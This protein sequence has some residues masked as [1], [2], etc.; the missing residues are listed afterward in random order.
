MKETCG[1]NTYFICLSLIY[2]FVDVILFIQK[3]LTSHVTKTI[4]EISDIS[5]LQNKINTYNS[6]SLHLIIGIADKALQAKNPC[7]AGSE[8]VYTLCRAVGAGTTGPT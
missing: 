7:V 3:A 4:Y 1:I 2:K 8:C 5:H 6:K